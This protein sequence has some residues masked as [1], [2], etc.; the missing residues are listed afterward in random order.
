[1]VGATRI[2]ESNSVPVNHPGPYCPL[3][4][5]K[6]YCVE[7]SCIF[8][9]FNISCAAPGDLP[10]AEY[11]RLE[12]PAT[13]D[14]TEASRPRTVLLE[15]A[16]IGIG[17][18]MAVHNTGIVFMQGTEVDGMNVD[19]GFT[20][21]DGGFPMDECGGHVTPPLGLLGDGTIARSIGVSSALYHFHKAPMCHTSTDSETGHSTQEGWAAD[22]VELYGPHDV[23][24]TAPVLD[25]CN[26]HFGPVP[27]GGADPVTYH[28]HTV[29]VDHYNATD[30]ERLAPYI[31]GCFGPAQGKCEELQ[32]VT[33]GGS[34]QSP[35]RNV[36][37]GAGCGADLCVQP[38][39]P[40]VVL[41]AY[42]LRVSGR[43][44]ED[45]DAWLASRT[46]NDYAE[47]D[48]AAAAT[49]SAMLSALA[50][51]HV[52]APRSRFG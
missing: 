51:S 40:P 7:A 1:M 45:L 4:S 34:V 37:C 29:D 28:Y 14:P 50:A 18:G 26:G 12:V 24:G 47:D 20:A 48:H 23:N 43:S 41:R 32:S 52:L 2:I 42:L 22:G 33:S 36:Y 5:G 39:T 8:N 15:D 35:V 25:E 9:S 38:G 31:L 17:V 3:G 10:G 21:T 27:D 49:L 30:G 16:P 46:T 13:P 11:L 44:S 19:V 6:G